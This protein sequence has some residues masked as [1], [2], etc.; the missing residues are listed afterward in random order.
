MTNLSI[1]FLIIITLFG[2]IY[3]FITKELKIA[4]GLL[5]LTLAF[6]LAIPNLVTGF[7]VDIL[8]ALS[9]IIYAIGIFIIVKHK[10]DIKDVKIIEDKKDKD[11]DKK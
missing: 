10:K 4:S 2:T 9:L 1:A 6:V 7:W 11:N 5:I 8:L 3:A